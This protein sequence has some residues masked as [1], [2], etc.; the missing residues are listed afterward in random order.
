[1]LNTNQELKFELPPVTR[2]I[3]MMTVAVYLL[4]LVSGAFLPFNITEMMILNRDA[5]AQLQ[6]WRFVTYIFLHGGLFHIFINM[7]ML[8]MFG[9]EMEQVLGSKRFLSLYLISGILGGLGW[10]LVSGND[11]GSCLGASGAVLGV[12]GA[13]GAIFPNR[14]ITL[15]VFLVLPVTMTARTLVIGLGII[16]IFPMMGRGGSN[17]AHAA[18]LF[19]GVAGYLYGRRLRLMP[20]GWKSPERRV[21]TRWRRKNIRIIPNDSFG[22]APSDGEVDDL[23]DKITEKGLGSLSKKE[24]E[25]LESASEHKRSE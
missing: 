1:M 5:V 25:I 3:L 15:L 8:V 20:G 12:L 24:R 17:I 10:L 6:L 21:D 7:F 13:F 9:R 16:S 19:G 22:D 11:G 18:H 23:L 14:K 4:Q 2:I